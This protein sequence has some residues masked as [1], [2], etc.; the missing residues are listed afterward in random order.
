MPSERNVESYAGKVASFV[1]VT[2][3]KAVPGCGMVGLGELKKYMRVQN[4][5]ED[6]L[7]CECERWAVADVEHETSTYWSWPREVIAYV[8]G[9]G[10]TMLPLP[11]YVARVFEVTEA[12]PGETQIL[13]QTFEANPHA[14]NPSA[15]DYVVR[16]NAIELKI[17]CGQWFPDVLYAVRYEQG[18]DALLVPADVKQAVVKLA[19]YCYDDRTGREDE[20]KPALRLFESRKVNRA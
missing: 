10:D 6:G 15:D 2:P 14:I 3:G 7:I 4:N 18:L 12:M 8:W 16:N 13:H 19:A 20:P 11:P 17:G 5:R 1:V 9:T